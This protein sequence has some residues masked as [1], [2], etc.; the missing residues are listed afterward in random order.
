MSVLKIVNKY[1]NSNFQIF[2]TFKLKKL[3]KAIL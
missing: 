3:Q 2:L 1:K